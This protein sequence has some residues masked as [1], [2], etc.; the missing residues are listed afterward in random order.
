MLTVPYIKLGHKPS[1]TVRVVVGIYEGAP[2]A[3]RVH[4]VVARSTSWFGA[5]TMAAC[6]IPAGKLGSSIS[7]GDG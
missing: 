1:T 5:S 4:P 7:T 3:A 2:Q 6:H